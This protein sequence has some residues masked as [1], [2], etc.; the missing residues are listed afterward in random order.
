M[1][2]SGGYLVLQ[3]HDEL[4]YEVCQDDMIPVAQIIQSEMENAMKLSVRLPVKVKAGPSW[5]KLEEINL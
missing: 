3:L 4:I 5:G 1:K 2:L